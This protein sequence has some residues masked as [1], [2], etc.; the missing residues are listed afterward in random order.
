M[1]KVLGRLPGVPGGMAAWAIFKLV[2]KI[3][4]HQDEASKAPDARPGWR[5]VLLAGAL[6][7]AI[8]AVKAAVDR[9]TA[10]GARIVTGALPGDERQQRGKAA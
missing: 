6:S 2:R 5:T 1:I 7:G 4:G 3:A 9:G 8:F 10:T